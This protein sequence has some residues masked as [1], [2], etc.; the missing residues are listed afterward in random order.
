MFTTEYIGPTGGDCS[1]PYA[2]KFTNGIKP[3][4]TEFIDHIL[5]ERN[6]EWG[7]VN[8][9][10]TN[11]GI[12]YKHGEIISDELDE[13]TKSLHIAEACAFGGY[14]RMDY[15]LDLED[16]WKEYSMKQQDL[17]KFL[18][19]LFEIYCTIVGYMLAAAIIIG[20]ILFLINMMLQPV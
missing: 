19:K 1:A 8:I 18:E 11:N 6:D 16:W 20:L 9:K 4:V 15:Y 17:K 12:K 5:K 14:T 13:D 2:V 10:H 3:T 7:Y